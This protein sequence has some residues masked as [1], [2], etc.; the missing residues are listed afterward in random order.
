M[1]A[2]LSLI[3]VSFF[4]GACCYPGPKA[5]KISVEEEMNSISDT[6]QKTSDAVDI[7]SDDTLSV[8]ERVFLYQKRME[9]INK[10]LLVN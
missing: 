9:E 8:G 10:R 4:L 3:I 6:L 5:P 1:R 7:L 2:I